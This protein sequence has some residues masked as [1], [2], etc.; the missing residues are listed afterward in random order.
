MQEAFKVQAEIEKLQGEINYHEN[1]LKER[2]E[3]MREL[4]SKLGM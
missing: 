4:Q 1:A 2:R 3:K